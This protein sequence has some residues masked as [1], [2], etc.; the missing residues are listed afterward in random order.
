MHRAETRNTPEFL[1]DHSC[2]LVVAGT[3]SLWRQVV[4][5]AVVVVEED[6]EWIGMRKDGGDRGLA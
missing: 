6:C 3:L 4:V 5:V 1:P 2:M